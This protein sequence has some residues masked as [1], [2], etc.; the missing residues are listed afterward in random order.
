[1]PGVQECILIKIYE[2]LPYSS[3]SVDDI[4]FQPSIRSSH[5]LSKVKANSAQW[6]TKTYVGPEQ[7]LL[8]FLK[9]DSWPAETFSWRSG[10]HSAWR[11]YGWS[12]TIW[13]GIAGGKR[14]ETYC[15]EAKEGGME[16]KI[17]H[18]GVTFVRTGERERERDLFYASTARVWAYGGYLRGNMSLRLQGVYLSACHGLSI[19]GTNGDVHELIFS[20]YEWNN[21][22]ALL[23]PVCHPFPPR[24]MYP[25]PYNAGGTA[26]LRVPTL[27][28]RT[29][30]D[31]AFYI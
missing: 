18:R 13:G 27:F 1:M 16:T 3:P 26:L 8:H 6:Y 5:L 22:L 30:R 11:K 14:C 15:L 7:F 28:V 31:V 19:Y 20:V 24:Q 17:P 23:I 4:Y 2:T 10:E 29:G 21:V 25:W 9:L 12:W